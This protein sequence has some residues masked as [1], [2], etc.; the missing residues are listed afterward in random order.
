MWWG[1]VEEIV[2]HDKDNTDYTGHPS[3]SYQL[4]LPIGITRTVEETRLETYAP[5]APPYHSTAPTPYPPVHV[6]DVAPPTVLPYLPPHTAWPHLP[7]PPTHEPRLTHPTFTPQPR[8][9]P[10]PLPPLRP[11]V[12]SLKPFE[13]PIQ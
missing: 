1:P 8:L 12:L 13:H 11:P 6:P 9:P 4:L 7:A 3:F 2:R 5:T 10:R